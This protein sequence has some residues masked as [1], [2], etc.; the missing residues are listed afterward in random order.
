M[1]LP[2]CP[3]HF[4]ESQDCIRPTGRVRDGERGQRTSTAPSSALS[5]LFIEILQLP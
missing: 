4:S 5:P 2:I 1:S 3:V